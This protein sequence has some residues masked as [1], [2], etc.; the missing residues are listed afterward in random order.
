MNAHQQKQ[1]AAPTKA[2]AGPNLPLTV[3]IVWAD[4]R[5]LQDADV[6]MAGQYMG[7]QPRRGLADLD[8]LVSGGGAGRHLLADL[9]CRDALRCAVGDLH[10]FP[11]PGNRQLLVLG[12][13]RQA[14]FS[15]AQLTRAAR[16]AA[17]AIG[18]LMSGGRVA[19]MLIGTGGGN[20]ETRD[21]V[22]GLL[23]GFLQAKSADPNLSF[24]HL[25]LVE[26]QLDRAFEIMDA[27]HDLAASERYAGLIA[28]GAALVEPSGGEGKISTHF[29][30]AMM[31]GGVARAWAEGP[32]NGLFKAAETLCAALP[33]R[34]QAKVQLGLSAHQCAAD[35]RRDG[36]RFRISYGRKD[37]AENPDRV[38]F[39]QDGRQIRTAAMT[40]LATVTER[41]LGMKCRWVDRIVDDLHAAAWT[42]GQQSIEERGR[43]AYGYLIH[44]DI[45]EKVADGGPLVFEVDRRLAS[46]PWEMLQQPGPD[47][48]PLG[49]HRP[50]A[51]QLRTI[52]SPRINASDRAAV[53]RALVIGDPDGTLEAAKNEAA[54]VAKLLKD[55]GLEVEICMLPPNR[56]GRGAFP[57]DGGFAEP[58]DLF[59]VVERLQNVRYD[60][61]HFA[62]HA[63]FSPASPETSGWVFAGGEVLTA[64][65][66]ENTEG[67]PALIF[68]NACLSAVGSSKQGGRGRGSGLVASLADEFM[69]RGV[70][71]YIGT[72]WLV[73]DK[74]AMPFAKDFYTAFLGSPRKQLGVALQEARSAAYRVRRVNDIWETAWATYQHYG[75][76]S[77]LF[78]E[79]S[80]TGP[81]GSLGR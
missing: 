37:E 3:E 57:F 8:T 9:I 30:Y 69:R 17:E 16:C 33:P 2:P 46:I 68:A 26:I 28:P 72:G 25:R 56:N 6:L 13:G 38:T 42:E 36:L 12:M 23:Q 40:N 39:S 14:L 79:T 71:D 29:G 19:S 31:L 64:A 52:Y 47:R 27:V 76:P 50:L 73:P 66:L 49:V 32:T 21:A 62:G 11:C 80:G 18:S 41:V 7:L 20:L 63:S 67:A 43:S 48:E 53:P 54:L 59:R 61:V 5:K 77:R 22:D 55:S 4:I 75:D 44:P 10:F 81:R 58:A 34:V 70:A 15:Q 24:A 1:P 51:R 65:M 35:P 45:R 74:V 60:I 78:P